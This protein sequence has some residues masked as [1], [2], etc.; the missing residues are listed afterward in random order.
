MR[1]D[2]TGQDINKRR[3]QPNQCLLPR[4][5]SFS[6]LLCMQLSLA[7]GHVRLTEQ[8]STGQY[9]TGQDRMEQRKET[10]PVL[11]CPVVPIM[12]RL[13]TVSVWLPDKEG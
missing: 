1:N 13:L 10:Q 3:S 11:R 5:L 2:R 9:K 4:Q 7:H 12:V 6:S 8:D